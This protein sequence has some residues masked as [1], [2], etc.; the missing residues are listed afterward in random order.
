MENKN[1]KKHEILEKLIQTEYLK[2]YKILNKEDNKTY[3][4]KTITLNEEES[5]QEIENI[6][7]TITQISNINTEYIIKYTKFTI[8]N[9]TIN[10]VT[11][12]IDDISLNLRQLITIHKNE[13]KSIS[14]NLIYSII[15]DI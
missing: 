3:I 14:Q 2:V 4:V 9:N 10:L 5:P 11:E 15:K 7:N 12:N 1:Q 6:K 13:K 8:K